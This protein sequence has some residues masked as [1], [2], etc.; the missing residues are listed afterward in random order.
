[1]L[2]IEKL[3]SLLGLD[4]KVV[5]IEEAKTLQ[6][7]TG[8]IKFEAVSFSYHEN[9]QILEN[10]DFT[11]SSGKKFAIVGTSGSGK[12]T[13]VKLLFR[14]YDPTNG[15]ILIDGHDIS[16]VTQKSL[17][18]IIGIV[19]QDTVLFND[20]IFENIRYGRPE[21]SDVDVSEAIKLA[22]LNDF[23]KQLPEHEET[24]V[25]ERG[26][27]LSGGEKQRVA[28][29]RMILKRPPIMVFDEAT[30]SL[31]SQS[32]QSVLTALNEI[33]V[34]VTTVVIAHR[35]S[36]IVDADQILVLEKGHLL[37]QGNHQQ[38]LEQQGKYSALWQAQQKE[39]KI[40]P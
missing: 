24:M 22:H 1:M 26:L 32:E 38:L 5:D 2:N 36:T 12:S 19:P 13:L 18:D 23:I 27:K 15:R 21:A 8:E 11:I 3:F 14:F 10:L 34:G 7:S 29:A 4:G 6:L 28:I 30:S 39:K 40:T 17:R 31:D 35:L 20:T 37:E 9:R 16:H 25:G 33:S